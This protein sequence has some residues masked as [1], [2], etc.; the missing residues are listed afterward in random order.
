MKT[1]AIVLVG[2]LGTRLKKVVSDVPKP[3]API[4]GEPFLTHL[5]RHLEKQKIQRV[6]LAA[7][8]GKEKIHAFAAKQNF[9]FS[10]DFSDEQTPLGTGGALMQA[11]QMAQA[12]NV[13]ALNGDTFFPIS[14]EQ[15]SKA[16]RQNSNQITLA[17]K[18]LEDASRYG[19][20]AVQGS[21][22]TAFQEKNPNSQNALINGGVFIVNRLA[23]TT[24]FQS[25]AFSLETQA[26]PELLESSKLGYCEFA[27]PF[28]DIGIPE[29]YEKA[30]A[31]IPQWLR[32]DE[33][34]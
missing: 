2:G 10:I 1:E 20:L 14:F 33:S 6:I 11:L 5:F 29:D 12:E 18:R 34:R 26:F 7:G 4:A 24:R 22:I 17:A 3:L 19:T 27:E 13:F 15:L 31:L 25:G 21:H 23:F 30:Q 16:H 28:I 32:E 8:Y 9:S